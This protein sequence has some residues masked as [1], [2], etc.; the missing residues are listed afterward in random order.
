MHVSPETIYT[1]IYPYPKGELIKQLVQ[2][3]RRA[4]SK[5]GARGTKD[6]C[7]SS[8]KVAH[9]QQRKDSAATQILALT[10][11]D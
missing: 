4:K 2:S 5:R 6:S 10:T 3:L 1:H 9:D 8:L 11:Y 7:Y